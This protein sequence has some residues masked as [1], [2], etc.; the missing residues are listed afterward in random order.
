M[1]IR[2][3]FSCSSV[4]LLG[5]PPPP[6]APGTPPS[7]VYPNTLRNAT[8]GTVNRYFGAGS[9]NDNNPP[10]NTYAASAYNLT[11]TNSP[12]GTVYRNCRFVGTVT[13]SQSLQNV[14][15]QWCVFEGRTAYADKDGHASSLKF[16]TVGS[17]L[18][19]LEN[20]HFENCTIYTGYD[21]TEP[22]FTR[23][24]QAGERGDTI[25]VLTRPTTVN[26]AAAIQLR[27]VANATDGL[28]IFHDISFSYCHIGLRNIRKVADGVAVGKTAFGEGYWGGS[29][30]FV[31]EVLD[32]TSG[33]YP[34]NPNHGFYNIDFD[35]CLI[36]AGATQT[37]NFSANRRDYTTPTDHPSG[38]STVTGCYLKGSQIVGRA[39]GTSAP[40]FP[41]WAGG[42]VIEA[43]VREMTVEDCVFWPAYAAQINTTGW[44]SSVDGYNVIRNNHFDWR[45]NPDSVPQRTIGTDG[46]IHN[47]G[48]R[49]TEVT[50]LNRGCVFPAMTYDTIT[51]NRFYAPTLSG[52]L[53][54]EEGVFWTL[55]DSIGNDLIAS[56]D[57]TSTV[58]DNQ[59][60]R[61][62]AIVGEIS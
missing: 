8:S 56:Q 25:T 10:A 60:I 36:E 17:N 6:D 1:G 5:P 22:T 43:G 18:S 32:V 14:T 12:P 24:R 62:G 2:H 28:G 49:P 40:Y 11:A 59:L 48:H 16:D 39:S 20:I 54:V 9:Y 26:R 27:P 44:G 55:A 33:S 58:S 45:S 23:A 50:A 51:G 57:A 34:Y 21:T 7:D 37:M 47:C 38:H 42:I 53:P 35:H 29:W 19:N 41:T 3:G 4:P 30:Y 52:G 46:S 13:Y 15:F 61:D 31:F